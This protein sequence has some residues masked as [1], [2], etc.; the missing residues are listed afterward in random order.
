MRVGVTARKANVTAARRTIDDHVGAGIAG[1]VSAHVF[2]CVFGSGGPQERG[3]EGRRICL[4]GVEFAS[5]RPVNPQLVF[6][7][8]SEVRRPLSKLR[9]IK[10]IGF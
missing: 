8:G 10:L 9:Q 2:R 7:P 1:V 5:V 4:H 3:K 6:V